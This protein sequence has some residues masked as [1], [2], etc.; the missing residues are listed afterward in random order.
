MRKSFLIGLSSLRSSPSRIIGPAFLAIN[1]FMVTFTNLNCPVGLHLLPQLLPS[2]EALSG[3]AC[4]APNPAHQ[5]P[6]CPSHRIGA[7][8]VQMARILQYSNE[9]FPSSKFPSNCV[10][11]CPCLQCQI[12]LFLKCFRMSG[13]RETFTRFSASSRGTSTT[14]RGRIFCSIIPPYFWISQQKTLSSFKS[15]ALKAFGF[16]TGNEP[17]KIDSFDALFCAKVMALSLS[18]ASMV[19]GENYWILINLHNC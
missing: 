6:P 8:F 9:T 10:T 13:V 2:S 4:I 11:S 19:G 7:A 18:A 12:Q 3:S 14:R 5:W 1:N 17:P 15:T 16:V